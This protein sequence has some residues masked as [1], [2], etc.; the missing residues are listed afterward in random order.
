M[1]LPGCAAM[2]EAAIGDPRRFLRDLF[3]VAVAAAHPG[4][5]VAANL[6]QPPR[7]RTLVIAVG[8]AALP[9]AEAVEENWPADFLG[10][11]IVPHG[12]A[13]SLRHFEVRHASH[14]V[15]DETSREAALRALQ[16][17]SELGP[18]DMLLALISGGGSSLMSAPAPG[19]EAADK[20]A[21]L[22]SLLKSGAGIAELNCVRKRISAVKGGRLAAAANGAK[23]CTLIISDVPGDDP[24]VVASGPTVADA[25]RNADALEVL[26]RYGLAMPATIAGI[27]SRPD[28]PLPP[29]RPDNE[30]R[31]IASPH[32]SFLAVLAKARETGI[33]A[34]FLGDRIEGEA[35]DVAKV[36]AAI[37]QEIVTYDAPARKPCLLLSGGETG[38]TV[39]GGGRG[40]RN[41]EF[42]L[43]LA[44]ALAGAPGVYAL[45]ADTD[46]IDGMEPIAGAIVAPDTLQRAHAIGLDARAMLEDNDA[47]RFF[48]ALGD[49]VITGP[50]NTNVNDFRA[51]LIR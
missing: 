10:L 12:Y 38:V 32:Q 17:A 44:I 6:P 31:V 4:R 3:D 27:L 1:V 14:P 24:A 40:G 9:T 7:G 25:T 29:L 16:L 8:K 19:I 41:V 21:L 39:R 28:D 34:L 30:T 13:I 26:R 46:G 18:N 5:A 20:I 2:S 33:A 51:I 37:A 23:I 45:A 50:T 36:H 15:P 42:S 43:A 47:H 11:A 22:R 49:Q 48:E 35:R